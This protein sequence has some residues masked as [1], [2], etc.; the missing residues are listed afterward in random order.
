VCA[1]RTE[2]QLERRLSAAGM[3]P[4]KGAPQVARCGVG[5]VV[6]GCAVGGC[7]DRRRPQARERSGRDGGGFIGGD[8]CGGRRS[9][10][11]DAKGRE[12]D[13]G[14]AGGAGGERTEERERM[15]ASALLLQPAAMA[16]EQRDR[17]RRERE[18]G[19]RL[20]FLNG[21]GDASRL[22]QLSHE[23]GH[24]SGYVSRHEKRRKGHRSQ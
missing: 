17:E 12:G 8:G 3:R 13:A 23:L 4:E 18:N 20:G 22:R 19:Q 2:A 14:A 16:G 1:W 11:P 24:T 15:K 10:A 21:H 5:T 9:G 6:L 7:E